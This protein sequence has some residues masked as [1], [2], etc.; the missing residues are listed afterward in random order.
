MPPTFAVREVSGLVSSVDSLTA[1]SAVELAGLVR[2]RQVGAA[3]VVRAHLERIR[4]VDPKLNAFQVVREVAVSE[5]EALDRRP[6]LAELPLAGVVVA[7]KDNVDVKGE[8]TRHGS[9]ATPSQAAD[10]DDELTLRLRR[11]GCIV[12][13]KTRMPELAIW[14][15]TESAAFGAVP[16]VSIASMLRAISP[17]IR[18]ATSCMIPWPICATR[19]LTS[20]S[21]E[22]A[23]CELP[24]SA[25]ATLIVIAAWAVP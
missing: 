17:I 10:E 13:G 16:V 25:G 14:P 2:G 18:V 3:E 5:A 24:S 23:T 1:K 9:A 15:F 20:R 8:P 7:V 11:A 12:I 22:T 6:D 19:P 4:V 21:V